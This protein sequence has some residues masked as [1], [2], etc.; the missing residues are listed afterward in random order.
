[1]IDNIITEDII[2]HPG[3]LDKNMNE[4]LLEQ[5]NNH[6]EKLHSNDNGYIINFKKIISYTNRISHI[7]GNIIFTTKSIA[8]VVKPSKGTK[9]NVIVT[10]LINHGI[11]CQ[12]KNIKVWIPSDKMNGYNFSYGVYK[13]GQNVI[14]KDD[15]IQVHILETRYEDHKFSCIALLT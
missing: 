14:Q 15:E 7:T 4:F 1:M 2:I 6:K 8:S 9:L 13:K 12:Y 10:M 5:L 11:L 3:D